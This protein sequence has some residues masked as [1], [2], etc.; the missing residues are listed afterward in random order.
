MGVAERFVDE[1]G[2]VEPHAV[3]MREVAAVGEHRP[4]AG[5]PQGDVGRLDLV[6]RR[7]RGE[8]EVQ[9]RAVGVAV[10]EVAAGDTARGRRR[11]GRREPR[12]TGRRAGTTARRSPSCRRRS[13]CGSAPAA[14][15][16]RCGARATRRRARRTPV[17]P[18]RTDAATTAIVASTIGRL[19]LVEHEQGAAGAVA[20]VAAGGLDGVVQPQHGRASRHCAAPCGRP[21]CRRRTWRTST[22]PG[23]RSGGSRMGAQPHPGDRSPSVPSE[24]R[25]S[26]LRSGPTAAAGAPPV[27]TTWP[28]ASTTSSP[29]TRSSI[30]PYRVEYWPAPRQ[31]TQPPTV[32]M[33]KLCGKWPTDSP[34]RSC[35]SSSRSGPNVPASTSTTPDST[36]TSPTPASPVRSSSTPPKTGTEPPHTPLRPP[37]TVTGTVVA[38]AGAQHGGDLLDRRRAH[39]DARHGRHLAGERP[40]HRQRPPVAAALGDLALVVDDVRDGPQLIEQ[41]GGADDGAG[42]AGTGP[43]ELDRRS[44][45]GHR[46]AAVRSA[47]LWCCHRTS[48]ATSSPYTPSWRADLGVVPPQLAREQRGDVGAAA[49]VAAS[50]EQVRPGAP[51]E[52]VL[53]R[54]RHLVACGV[55]GLG[56]QVRQAGDER[57]TE[58]R[59]GVDERGHLGCQG[60]VALAEVDVGGAVRRRLVAVAAE[61]AE[62][63]WSSSD[64]CGRGAPMTTSTVSW[65]ISR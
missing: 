62:G 65:A 29:T 61:R 52:H 14:Q 55:D 60:A 38:G 50:I 57:L 16:C 11:S 8:R 4:L 25:N 36:S 6:R 13:P 40:V 34:W 53:E 35:S 42:P 30:L 64:P 28:S 47:S 32:A 2:P 45:L 18:R 23:A 43:G 63:A 3:V 31:A 12:R 1:P 51:G 33:S 19:A 54:R 10:R 58:R 44:R 24:P 17:R 15:R 59:I 46:V 26:W 9:A 20:A 49:R 7:C 48:V 27:R 21:R 22:P 41:L 56:A 39:G 37:A 5:V